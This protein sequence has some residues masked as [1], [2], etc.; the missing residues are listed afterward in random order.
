[1]AAYFHLSGDPS[2]TSAHGRPVDPGL[3]VDFAADGRPLGIEITAPAILS[4]EHFNRVLDELGLPAVTAEDLA[5][6]RG[7]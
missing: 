2:E 1:M 5:P 3:V 6:L 4:L 7:V